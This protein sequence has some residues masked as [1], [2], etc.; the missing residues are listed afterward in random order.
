[1]SRAKTAD[2]EY[3]E[4]ERVALNAANAAARASDEA[5]GAYEAIRNAHDARGDTHGDA[6]RAV[7]VAYDA[8]EDTCAV[9]AAAKACLYAADWLRPKFRGES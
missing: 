6:R 7:R 9:Y 8:Y 3:N 2:A 5:W 4:A 1:M